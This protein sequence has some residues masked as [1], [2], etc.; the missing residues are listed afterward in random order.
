[1]H[2]FILI[3]FLFCA[4]SLKGEPLSC[5]VSGRSAVLINGTTGKILFESEKDLAVYPASTTKV[6]TALYILKEHQ[7]RLDDLVTAHSAA[8]ATISPSAKHESGYRSPSY[9]LETDG[10]HMGIKSGEEFVLKDLLYAMLINSPNDAANV[11]AQHFGEGKIPLFMERVNAFTKSLGCKLTHLENPH[12]L[13][14]P[15]HQTTAFEMATLTKEAMRDPL[16]RDIVCRSYYQVPQTN[17]EYERTLKQTNRLVRKGNDF[18]PYAL[19][20]KTGTTRAAGKCLIT[21]AEKGGRLLIAALFGYESRSALYQDMRQLFDTAFG[22]PL[23]RRKLL[24]AKPRTYQTEIQGRKRS[25]LGYIPSGLYYDF[26]PSERSRVVASIAYHELVLPVEQGQEIGVI[27]IR[28]ESGALVASHPLFAFAQVRATFWDYIRLLFVSPQRL[29]FVIAAL[30][31][32][33]ILYKFFTRG[34]RRSRTVRF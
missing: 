11:L 31:V 22:E 21:A 17:L 25:V 13:H 1:V 19:G 8:L 2:R 29:L 7:D 20:G 18:Y 15:L 33:F 6:V 28:D 14:H 12:G 34:R 30:V 26:Y 27:H 32:I 5:S 3:I 16:F 24:D 10:G 9:W 23:M 4:P